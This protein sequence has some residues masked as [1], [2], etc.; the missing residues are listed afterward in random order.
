MRCCDGKGKRGADMKRVH[1]INPKYM[2][3]EEI[4]FPLCYGLTRDYRNN[5]NLTSD[6]GAVTCRL[7][8][9]KM[10]GSY[11]LPDGTIEIRDANG[12]VS[13]VIV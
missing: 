2:F 4:N 9:R 13:A 10:A 5:L 11:S 8:L 6:R 1:L 7:C 3:P 12:N